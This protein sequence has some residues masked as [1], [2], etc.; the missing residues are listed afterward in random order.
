[1]A[2]EFSSISAAARAAS[3]SRLLVCRVAADLG[4]AFARVDG[5]PMLRARDVKRIGAAIAASR[6][7]RGEQ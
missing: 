3:A 2:G 5:R 6:R 4:V 7:G 1:M